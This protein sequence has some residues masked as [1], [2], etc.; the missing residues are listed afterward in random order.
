MVRSIIKRL[1]TCGRLRCEREPVLDS[2]DDSCSLEIICAVLFSFSCNTDSLSDN[3]MEAT[4]FLHSK[5]H[6]YSNL[7]D[8]TVSHQLF[9][10][11]CVFIIRA[12]VVLK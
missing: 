3:M 9:T 12:K 2:Q 8:D 4:D 10:R 1:L 11:R 6:Q 7:L 5:I